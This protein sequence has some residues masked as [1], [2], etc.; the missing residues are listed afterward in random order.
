MVD[1]QEA[2]RIIAEVARSIDRR[3]AVEVREV[4]GGERLHLLLTHTHPQRH[5]EIELGLEQVLAAAK[6]AMA[7]NEVRLRIKRASDTMLFRPVPDHRLDVKP[8]APPGGQTPFR[9][10]RGRGR[11]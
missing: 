11:R 3:L 8:V 4:P 1:T 6:S 5:G 7:R 2:R 9:T 10:P